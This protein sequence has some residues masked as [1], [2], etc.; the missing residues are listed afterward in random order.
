M[1][2]I[3]RL[4]K[5]GL[6]V[7]VPGSHTRGY[8]S[9]DLPKYKVVEGAIRKSYQPGGLLHFLSLIS[10]H[11]RLTVIM[12]ESQ[13]LISRLQ[14]ELQ[15]S[16]YSDSP[17]QSPQQIQRADRLQSNLEVRH[18]EMWSADTG[19]ED[20]S[21]IAQHSP[22]ALRQEMLQIAGPRM[23][24]RPSEPSPP[25]V[26]QKHTVTAQRGQKRGLPMDEPVMQKCVKR[27]RS[28]LDVS[29]ET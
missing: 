22:S 16:F 9:K 12:N 3:A 27:A 2:I 13:L 11:V 7:D 10:H 23:S 18:R 8:S 17:P 1:S 15:D 5:Y 14:Y 4:K 26:R 21:D 24:S 20:L 19:T 25:S 28:P 29:E 6:I